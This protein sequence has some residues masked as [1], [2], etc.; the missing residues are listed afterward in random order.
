MRL[1]PWQRKTVN[2]TI[3]SVTPEVNLSAGPYGYRQATILLP[4]AAAY[5]LSRDGNPSLQLTQQSVYGRGG[6]ASVCCRKFTWDF[7][8]QQIQP[9][10]PTLTLQNPSQGGVLVGT[11][12]L[13]S[14]M[15]Q[16]AGL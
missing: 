1:L 14:L 11:F 8:A 5:A 10:I 3:H 15:P 13:T 6:Y 9:V 12:G 16:S 4:G 2:P 7:R